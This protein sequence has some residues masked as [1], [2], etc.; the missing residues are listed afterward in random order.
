M[1]TEN[2]ASDIEIA[3]ATVRA[4]APWPFLARVL[5][6][7]S[8]AERERSE[9]QSRVRVL[10]AAAV[11]DNDPRFSSARVTRED[12]VAMSKLKMTPE[13]FV[14]VFGGSFVLRRVERG[15]HGSPPSEPALRSGDPSGC[16]CA[17]EHTYGAWFGPCA[18]GK[19]HRPHCPV[20]VLAGSRWESDPSSS[21]AFDVVLTDLR[22]GNSV[23]IALLGAEEI[24]R[25]IVEA[26]KCA[27]PSG[28]E[29][30]PY[31][32][33]CG[34]SGAARRTPVEVCRDCY[35][36]ARDPH[37]ALRT[38]A[39]LFLEGREAERAEWLRAWPTT[40]GP[41]TPAEL[42]VF[43]QEYDRVGAEH[44]AEAVKNARAEERAEIVA[45]ALEMARNSEAF[46]MPAKAETLRDLV[47]YIESRA[48]A[49][50]K[51]G[52]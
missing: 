45:K 36:V 50:G 48:H 40:S 3:I 21:G 41:K 43:L 26:M 18:D 27:D 22:M 11:H 52:G 7:F 34:E 17:Q 33:V 9:A 28:S 4:Y 2:E 37:P 23:C 30:E 12:R 19:N 14:E 39:P 29:D 42:T 31:C 24:A 46:D 51:G 44:Q 47:H 35:E 15:I 16:V 38:N 32:D 25:E 1:T 8:R 6:R 10:E 20:A 49:R 13:K 5:T